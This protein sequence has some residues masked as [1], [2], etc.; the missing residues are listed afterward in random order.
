MQDTESIY[1]VVQQQI[2]KRFGKEFTWE[3]KAKMMGRKALPA[4]EALI[5]ELQL[6]GRISAEEFVKEREQLLHNKFPHCQLMPGAQRL[7]EHLKKH[8]I[9]I[10]VATSSHARHTELKTSKHRGLFSSFDHILT[11]DVVANGKPAPDIFLV[12]AK[13]WNPAPQPAQCL[14]FEDAPL[15]VEAGLAAGMQVVMVPDPNLKYPENL[16]PTQV[17]RS[18]Q[19]FDPERF[20]LPGYAPE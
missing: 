1:T 13:Q 18:L 11:G 8:K 9:P 15:G 20:G 12:A 5:E 3:L 19:D 6:Q 2:C 7:I 14:V 10:C 17:L 16:Q 4:A